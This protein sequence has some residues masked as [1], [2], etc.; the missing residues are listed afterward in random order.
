MQGNRQIR[1]SECPGWHWHLMWMGLGAWKDRVSLCAPQRGKPQ[2]S[3]RRKHGSCVT[4]GMVIFLRQF[5]KGGR[6]SVCM[7]PPTGRGPV[8]C[9]VLGT[10][11]SSSRSTD[12]SRAACKGLCKA[13][14]ILQP[15]A[16]PYGIGPSDR[17]R[18]RRMQ[19][20]RMPS[21]DSYSL[22]Y[23]DPGAAMGAGWG[24]L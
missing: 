14:S 1:K 11:T 19:L 8:P 10:E 23:P 6:K 4:L 24:S 16:Q 9:S 17:Y 15:P 5:I 22:G 7:L 2:A 3:P 18:G 13:S 12:D 21:C 20:E